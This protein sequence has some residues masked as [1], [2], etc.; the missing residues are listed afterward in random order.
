MK[1]NNREPESAAFPLAPMIDVVFLLLIFFIATMQ[2]SQSER[3]LNVSVPV[4]EEG[5]DAQQ[6]VGEII[7]NVKENGEVVVDNSVMSQDQLYAKLTR[8]AAVHKNQAIR[9]RGDGKVEY[10][11]IVQVI[12]VCQKAGIPNISFATQVRKKQ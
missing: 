12:D 7:V 3:E 10:Q 1:F 11:K 4:A 6:T 2:F 9:I 5:A 8:I